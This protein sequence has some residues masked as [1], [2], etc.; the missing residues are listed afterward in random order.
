MKGTWF[1]HYWDRDR[2]AHWC[3]S[4][5]PYHRSS[6]FRPPSLPSFSTPSSFSF[7][8]PCPPLL[9]SQRHLSESRNAI[10]PLERWRPEHS[11]IF[12]GTHTIEYEGQGA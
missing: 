10:R 1:D 4:F 6:T 5:S 8:Y 3:F 11:H 7:S 12:Y 2:H 9:Y